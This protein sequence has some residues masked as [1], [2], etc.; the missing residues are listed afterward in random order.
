MA[1]VTCF[2]KQTTPTYPL[3]WGQTFIYQELSVTLSAK[4]FHYG[5]KN[6]TGTFLNMWAYDRLLNQ[7]QKPKTFFSD[8]GASH[9]DGKLWNFYEFDW[10]LQF[11][12]E[13]I[14]EDLWEIYER[15]HADKYPIRL[16]DGRLAMVDYTTR[17]R[18]RVGPLLPAISNR[19]N[20]I[21]YWP[22]FNVEMDLSGDRL[23]TGLD[24]YSLV[25]KA[26]EYDPDISVPLS[27]DRDDAPYLA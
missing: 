23:R 8:L 7:A 3:G 20:R 27:E 21:R 5:P 1:T 13:A 14:Y 22:Q 6:G 17:K 9:W 2:Y 15:S 4:S 25:M 26:K 11:L 18:A 24:E 19:P 12:T 10:R 16:L